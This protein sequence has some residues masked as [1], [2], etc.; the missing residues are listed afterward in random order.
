MGSVLSIP[1]LTQ[2]T[3]EELESTD[4]EDSFHSQSSTPEESNI[5]DCNTDSGN[6]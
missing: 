6:E 1:Y 2:N 3:Q 5:I 4:D